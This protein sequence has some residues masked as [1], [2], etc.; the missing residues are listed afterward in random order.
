MYVSTIHQM[1]NVDSRSNEIHKELTNGQKNLSES[2]VQKTV[3]AFSVFINPFDGG[4]CDL[5]NLASGQK[6]PDEVAHD[7]LNI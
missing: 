5:V 1:T 7:L 2:K 3:Q 6:V 4:I